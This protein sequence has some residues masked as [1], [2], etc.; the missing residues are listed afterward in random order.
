MIIINYRNLIRDLVLNANEKN[1]DT[2]MDI[3]TL[4]SDINEYNT[5]DLKFSFTYTD[6]FIE[7]DINK[8]EDAFIYQFLYNDRIFYYYNTDSGLKSEEINYDECK[9][10]IKGLINQDDILLDSKYE[11]G[12]LS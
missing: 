9:N 12:V 7:L 3:I 2:I 5:N 8:N 11:V 1:I 10:L 6:K 4:L